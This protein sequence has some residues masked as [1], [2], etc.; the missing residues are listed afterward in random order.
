MF[1]R[2]VFPLPLEQSFLYAVPEA[3]RAAARPGVRVVAPLGTRRQNGFIVGLTTEPPAAGVKVK[4]LIQVL[5]DRPFR[6][7]RFLDFTGRLSAESHSSWGE[8]LQTALP[9]SLAGKTRVAVVLS[10]A[11]HEALEAGGLGPKARLLAG[12][13]GRR[14][15]GTEPAAPPE[16][17]GWRR[18]LRP[19]LPDG[20]GRAGRRGADGRAASRALPAGR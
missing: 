18:Y 2:V 8:I 10:A 13:S 1:A 20:E 7:K 6:D 3:F 4:E 17:A 15:E 12:G 9:P 11:G 5:D 14:A 16:K 19:R